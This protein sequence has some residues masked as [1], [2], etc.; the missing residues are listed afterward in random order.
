M[1]CIDS[2]NMPMEQSPVTTESVAQPETQCE[3]PAET[4]ESN[5]EERVQPW[6]GHWA[7]KRNT[8][9]GYAYGFDEGDIVKINGN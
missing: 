1:T 8:Q 2:F 5:S 3:I 4:E 7:P 9:V 6:K